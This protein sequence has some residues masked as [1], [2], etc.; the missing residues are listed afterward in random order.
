MTVE[1]FSR[2][3]PRIRALDSG[4]WIL[5]SGL[6]TLD[7][8]AV[9]RRNSDLSL[10]VGGC[11]C[12]CAWGG[13]PKRPVPRPFLALRA[14]LVIALHRLPV[15]CIKDHIVPLLYLES[16]VSFGCWVLLPSPPHNNPSAFTS[17]H[18]TALH[19]TVF[20]VTPPQPDSPLFQMFV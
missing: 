15:S 8:L 13:S 16:Y 9:D 19:C 11:E 12:A 20:A 1:R 3:V 10:G 6:W 14:P 5:D 18:G 7:P 4:F 17:R 2:R